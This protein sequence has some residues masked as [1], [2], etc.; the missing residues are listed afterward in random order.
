MNV[1]VLGTG[2]VGQCFAAKISD[3]GHSVLVGTRDPT[4]TLA[5]SDPDAMGNPPFRVWHEQHPAVG[6]VTFAA[7]AAQAEVVF[8]ALSGMGALEALKLAGA[9]NLAGKVLIDASNPLDFSKGMPPT[10]SVC[11]VDSLGEQIQRAFPKTKVVKSLNTVN[12]HLMVDPQSLA[13]GDHTMLSP[14]T[15]RTRKPMRRASCASGLVGRT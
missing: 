11:N 15:T 13:G 5:R 1:A 4:R 9:E 3:L 10:L 8:S 14:G 6:L 12:A 2:V 7:A